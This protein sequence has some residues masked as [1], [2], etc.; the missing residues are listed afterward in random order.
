MPREAGLRRPRRQ[1]AGR[2]DARVSRRSSSS[3]KSAGRRPP[4]GRPA[5]ATLRKEG[6]GTASPAAESRGARRGKG[7]GWV[8]R[9]GMGMMRVGRGEYSFLYCISVRWIDATWTAKLVRAVLGDQ[10]I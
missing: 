1:P 7:I 10:A 4:L 2:P 3:G 5:S 8:A 6:G 9:D